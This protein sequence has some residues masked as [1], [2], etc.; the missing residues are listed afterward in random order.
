MKSAIRPHELFVSSLGESCANELKFYSLTRDLRMNQCIQRVELNIDG[1][2]YL[3]VHA[4][5]H[6]TVL[7]AS[8][9]GSLFGLAAR[10]SK[11]IQNLAPSFY[12]LER[13]I[14]YRERDDEFKEPESDEELNEILEKWELEHENEGLMFLDKKQRKLAQVEIDIDQDHNDLFPINE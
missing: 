7:M 12:E 3:S 10:P 6:F 9:N 14:W 2:A 11:M 4:K 13:N 5:L 1:C 8:N